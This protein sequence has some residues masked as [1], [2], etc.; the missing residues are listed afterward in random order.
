M[1]IR[2]VQY[3]LKFAYRNTIVRVSC[4]TLGIDTSNVH[5]INDLHKTGR[6]LY[7]KMQFY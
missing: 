1:H 7:V 6:T 5:M 4:Y 3:H 2:A